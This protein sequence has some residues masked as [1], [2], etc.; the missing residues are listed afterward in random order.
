MYF[1]FCALQDRKCRVPRPF[2][3]AIRE[4]GKLWPCDLPIFGLVVSLLL[5]QGVAAAQFQPTRR[6]LILNEVNPSYPAD[7]IVN[8]GIQTA[9][10]DSP[11]RLEFYSEYLD[12]LLFPDP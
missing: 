12:S 3:E 9:L 7:T 10:S 4:Q 6:I 5:I 1:G 2:G 11:Y 8:Q